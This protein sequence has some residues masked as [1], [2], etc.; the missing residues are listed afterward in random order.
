[1]DCKASPGSSPTR[2]PPRIYP[3]F[4]DRAAN[5][6]DSR[7]SASLVANSFAVVP[8]TGRGDGTT[9]AA[10]TSTPT[11]DEAA[12]TSHVTAT[13]NRK[14]RAVEDATVA[15]L[16]AS[17]PCSA[18]GPPKK[19]QSTTQS[20]SNPRTLSIKWG[21]GT[22]TT[23]DASDSIPAVVDKAVSLAQRAKLGLV[24]VRS[25]VRVTKSDQAQ[26]QFE[27]AKAMP[28]TLDLLPASYLAHFGQ[29]GFY[30]R[31]SGRDPVLVVN[32]LD[33]HDNFVHQ[34]WAKMYH[35]VSVVFYKDT[36]ACLPTV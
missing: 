21:H 10:I 28:I 16:E 34:Q 23:E 6:T 25:L 22:D 27:E 20:T 17:K 30:C 36:C 19:K 15:T 3:L 12:P 24:T 2:P 13:D 32:P 5:D 11:M 26:L 29:I 18:L 7:C 8:N 35:K 31:G 33:I 14:R 1:M 9:A 4:S